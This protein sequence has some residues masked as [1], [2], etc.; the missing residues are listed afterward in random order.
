MNRELSDKWMKRQFPFNQDILACK[1]FLELKRVRDVLC[2][3]AKFLEGKYGEKELYINDDWHEHDSYVNESK[4]YSWNKL[5]KVYANDRALYNSRHG[6]DFV[7]KLIHPCEYDF[8]LRYYIEDESFESAKGCIEFIGSVEDLMVIKEIFTQNKVDY[9][10]QNA[11]EY[12]DS[13]YCG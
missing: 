7:R 13:R 9:F 3:I 11:C 12:F 6:D 8:I 2:E 1:E 5:N 10:M 4:D